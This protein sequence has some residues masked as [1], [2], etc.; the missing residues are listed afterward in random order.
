MLSYFLFLFFS[1]NIAVLSIFAR[2]VKWNQVTFDFLLLLNFIHATL[3]HIYIIYCANISI[4]L[5]LMISCMSTKN[6]L[7]N[8]FSLL[9]KTDSVYHVFSRKFSGEFPE[10]F[11]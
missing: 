2:Y 7:E 5:Y 11:F 9:K 3:S 10:R 8:E 1:L 4:K 6:S